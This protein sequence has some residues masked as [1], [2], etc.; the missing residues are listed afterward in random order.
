MG[1]GLVGR[2]TSVR[3]IDGIEERNPV[4]WHAEPVPSTEL[5][6][7]FR[8]RGPD[9]D[10]EALSKETGFTPTRTFAK[11]ELPGRGV[12]GVAGW[13]W[14]SE[15]GPDVEA[16]L[17]TMVELLGPHATAI[18][19]RVDAGATAVLTVVGAVTGDVLLTPVE[20]EQRR[21]TVTPDEPFEPLFDG[22]RIGLWFDPE[23]MAFL[24]AV[25]C[26]LGTHI[27][28]E[29]ERPVSSDDE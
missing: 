10:P 25:G 22:D 24:A 6:L 5:H 7:A 12:V 16:L 23:V 28:V 27:D 3:P 29:L 8:L 13:D 15:S 9:L 20:A 26:S 17:Q 4:R 19:A 14:R 2:S 1:I 18:R 21:I 11:G